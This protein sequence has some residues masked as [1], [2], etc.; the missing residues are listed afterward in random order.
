MNMSTLK[1]LTAA[2]MLVILCFSLTACITVVVEP[3]A[4]TAAATTPANTTLP[5]VPETT[6]PIVTTVP[7]T[8]APVETTVPTTTT[9]LDS[10]DTDVDP[11][12]SGKWEEMQFMLDGTLF[13]LPMTVQDLEDAGW[14]V[15]LVTSSFEEG[16]E[17]E[18]GTKLIHPFNVS[19]PDYPGN[20]FSTLTFYVNF[21]NT[22][23]E[24]LP[25]R[26]C[27]IYSVEIDVQYP[28][29]KGNPYPEFVL[30]NGVKLGDSMETVEALCGIDEN[31]YH[32]ESL[33]YDSVSYSVSDEE[34]FFRSYEL[35][36]TVYPDRGVTKI[37]LYIYN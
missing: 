12:L 6:A 21:W 20:M 13:H 34:I 15:E 22:T 29:E 10:G 4:T 17:L 27:E 32:A 7:E 3:P 18:G 37:R 14:T 2:I 31:K 28:M 36:L 30:G 16:Y 1:K 8:T 24:P 23:D 9:P 25:L 11:A 35:R 26:E 5:T 33:G 19:H